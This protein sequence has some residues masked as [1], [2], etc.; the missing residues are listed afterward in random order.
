MLSN[1]A[2]KATY[3]GNGVMVPSNKV[4]VT[5]NGVM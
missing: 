5:E 1:I 4:M 2:K 3:F